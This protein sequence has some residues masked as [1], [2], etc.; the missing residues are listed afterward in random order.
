MV[1]IRDATPEERDAVLRR[2]GAP[3]VFEI[4]P[5]RHLT[6]ARVAELTGMPREEFMRGPLLA[7]DGPR[8]RRVS[9]FE[10]P[11][12]FGFPEG[13]SFLVDMSVVRT[14]I[15]EALGGE[16]TSLE[17]SAVLDVPLAIVWRGLSDLVKSR[18]V[19]KIKAPEGN[20]FRLEVAP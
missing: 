17:L 10:A 8:M 3:P 14:R 4:P 1:T 12:V 9:L 11:L 19:R 20:R 2:F 15:I 13:E 7:V 5:A 16:M 6:P 18:V